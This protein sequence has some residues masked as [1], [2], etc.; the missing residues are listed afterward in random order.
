[1]HVRRG[2]VRYERSKVCA[3]SSTAKLISTSKFLSSVFS[4]SF[5][6]NID[7]SGHQK[8]GFRNVEETEC[9]FGSFSL[10]NILEPVP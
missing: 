9:N 1:M 8:S 4:C 3:L 6:S 5:T 2:G 7:S 10:E